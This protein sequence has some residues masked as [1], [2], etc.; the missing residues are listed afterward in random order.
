[1]FRKEHRRRAGTFRR[2]DDGPQ[3]A[4]ILQA[5][6]QDEDGVLPLPVRQ[7]P[8]QICIFVGLQEG[9]RSLMD[10]AAGHIVQ[11]LFRHFLHR[12]SIFFSQ[13][14]HGKKAVILLPFLHEYLP[15]A[16]TF[17]EFGDAVS[18]TDKEGVSCP[19]LLCRPSPFPGKCRFPFAA[20]SGFERRSFSFIRFH[21]SFLLPHTSGSFQG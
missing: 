9:R 10:H 11:P 1:M 19:L 21:G 2:T 8:V 16:L 17:Q 3:I 6:Q 18:A 20:P 14:Y 5:V 13:F 15:H 7:H 12:H 4:Y